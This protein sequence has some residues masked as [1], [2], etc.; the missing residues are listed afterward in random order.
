MSILVST[1]SSLIPRPLA[2]KIR[3]L[4]EEKGV[5]GTTENW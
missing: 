1:L 3:A 5:E 2:P 4:G